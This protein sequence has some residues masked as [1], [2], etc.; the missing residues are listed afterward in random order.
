MIEMEKSSYNAEFLDA[1][2]DSSAQSLGRQHLYFVLDLASA[3]DKDEIERA[4][5]DCIRAY[6]ILGCCYARGL[7]RDKWTADN[8]IKPADIITLHQAK[9]NELASITNRIVSAQIDPSTSWPWRIDLIAA[10]DRHRLIITTL[11]QLGDGAG[12]LAIVHEL[13]R[14][15]RQGQ[16]A[17]PDP[18][19]LSRGL[20]QVVR[21][22]RP[23][24]IPRLA[25]ETAVDWLRPLALLPFLAKTAQDYKIVSPRDFIAAVQTFVV[26][27]GPESAM[28]KKTRE[29]QVTINDALVAVIAMLAKKLSRKGMVAGYFTVN[30]RRFLP[31]GARRIANLSAINTVIL[32]RQKVSDFDTTVAHV[33]KKISAQKLRFPGLP[34]MVVPAMISFTTP[35]GIARPVATTLAHYAALAMTRGLL[36]TN[37]GPIDQFLEPWGEQVESASLIG[38]FVTGLKI[39]VVTVTGFRERLTIQ[40][41]G[42]D[43]PEGVTTSRV[44]A[45]FAETFQQCG[46][47]WS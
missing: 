7:W 47:D 40:L 11:H 23:R 21:G 13:G 3:I 10:G 5:A 16:D 30:L 8:S 15:L 35:H 28:Q 44:A 25:Y 46:F 26:P 33:A 37:L 24:N 41:N 2:Y 45:L 22:L 36:V 29:L 18:D 43:G 39:P 14:R 34:F 12:G 1:A 19:L 4:V 6:P 42:C 38:P 9:E 20:G 31:A 27:A 32:S 17:T